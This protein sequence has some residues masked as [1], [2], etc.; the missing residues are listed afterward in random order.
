MKKKTYYEMFLLLYFTTKKVSKCSIHGQL[1][2]GEVN[3]CF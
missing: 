3:K 1:P 2:I